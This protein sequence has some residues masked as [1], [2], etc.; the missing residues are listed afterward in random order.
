MIDL[1][2]NVAK[3]ANLTLCEKLNCQAV[4]FVVGR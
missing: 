4:S 2:Q 3:G 1:K